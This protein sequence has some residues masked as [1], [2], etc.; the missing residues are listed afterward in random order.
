MEFHKQKRLLIK[1]IKVKAGV[2][3]ETMNKIFHLMV[4]ETYITISMVKKE[5]FK[6]HK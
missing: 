5:L 4:T 2:F 6:T 1:A 3:R